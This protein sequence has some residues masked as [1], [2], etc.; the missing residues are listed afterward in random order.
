MSQQTNGVSRRAFLRGSGAV[1]AAS[2]VAASAVAQDTATGSGVVAGE[3]TISLKVNGKSMTAKV[4]PRTTL[5]DM[6]RYQ[7][8]LTAAK[9][10]F[11]ARL[12]SI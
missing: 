3:T 4:E 8:D 12:T 1:A 10:V 2:T 6:L 9:P 11:G 7:F 5:L